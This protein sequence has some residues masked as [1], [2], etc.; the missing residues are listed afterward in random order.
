MTPTKRYYPTEK[1]I[2][3]RMTRETFKRYRQLALQI[4]ESTTLDDDQQT[5]LDALKS[6]PG[7]PLDYDLNEGEVLQPEV[8][9]TPQSVVH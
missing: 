3:W 1:K 2:L 4:G 6:L 9:D 8:V 5:A 7:Y